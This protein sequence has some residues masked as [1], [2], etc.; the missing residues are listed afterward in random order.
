MTL[1]R[2][3]LIGL[4]LT[5]PELSFLMNPNLLIQTL[6]ITRV[7]MLILPVVAVF[8]TMSTGKRKPISIS[9]KELKLYLKA[10]KGGGTK[11]HHWKVFKECQTWT[12][13]QSVL[14]PGCHR[15]LTAALVF[16]VVTFVDNYKQVG[17][18]YSDPAAVAFVEDNKTYDEDARLDFFPYDVNQSMPSL[19]GR[20]YDLL[21]SLSAGL[22][23]EPCAQYVKSGGYLLVN[24]SHC[25]A[26]SMFL[27]PQSWK[28]A[29]Y[30]DE[31]KSSFTS[32]MIHRCFQVYLPRSK[33]DFAPIS[34]DQVEESL[35]VGSISKRSFKMVFEPLFYLFQRVESD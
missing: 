16:P 20:S 33:T 7:R 24:D 18:L 14:Y 3:N 27:Q 10:Y 34:I 35:K 17:S 5:N 1:L 31:D 30:W 2:E 19:K 23:A 29:A 15:H 11:D 25:D 26:R 9:Q 12:S 13:A 22:M 6:A 21:I 32:E 4:K 28:L 8:L